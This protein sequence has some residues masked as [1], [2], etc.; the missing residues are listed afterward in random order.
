[1]AKYHIIFTIEASATVE[2]IGFHDAILKAKNADETEGSIL[3]L[4]NVKGKNFETK[5]SVNHSYKNNKRN[6]KAK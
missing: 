5:E 1:M 2:A 4:K 6:R 3:N